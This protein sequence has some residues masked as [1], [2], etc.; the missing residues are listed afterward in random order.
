[1]AS[2]VVANTAQPWKSD[3]RKVGGSHQS[4]EQRMGY[5]VSDTLNRLNLGSTAERLTVFNFK[6]PD[7]AIESVPG[8]F[9]ALVIDNPNYA[10][11]LTLSSE[12]D[13]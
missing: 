8:I 9:A 4:R 3:F 2:V 6:S 7:S 5:K 13:K 12:G 11:S 10:D 1:M